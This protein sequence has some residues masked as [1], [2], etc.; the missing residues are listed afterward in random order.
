M[1]NVR[2]D[3]YVRLQRPCRMVQQVV[4]EYYG[5]ELLAHDTE[6][7]DLGM[8]RYSSFRSMAVQAQNFHRKRKMN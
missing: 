8:I 7:T 4:R 2:Q 5:R 1:K 6:K 3:S